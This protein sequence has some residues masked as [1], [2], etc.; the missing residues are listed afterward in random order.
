MSRMKLGV[1]IPVVL[2]GLF[3]AAVVQAQVAKKQLDAVR[4]NFQGASGLLGEFA[5]DFQKTLSAKRISAIPDLG[6][7]GA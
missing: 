3:R 7:L 1:A 5:A 4:A 2:I 6:S